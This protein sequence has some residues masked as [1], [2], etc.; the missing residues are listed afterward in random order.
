V[1]CLSTTKA[2]GFFEARKGCIVSHHSN[3]KA[4]QIVNHRRVRATANGPWP[5]VEQTD[6][7]TS[8]WQRP[9]R[10]PQFALDPLPLSPTESAY[11][12]EAERGL[13]DGR[14]TCLPTARAAPL[15]SENCHLAGAQ[16]VKAKLRSLSLGL[17]SPPRRPTDPI[18]KAKGL[19]QT[20]LQ[21]A[22]RA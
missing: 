13:D 4:S 19:N 15:L 12:R 16:A 10:E 7:P 6:R 2:A 5:I 9:Y 14:R 22:K 8:R 21:H 20:H 3:L 1:G 17:D 18:K 11:G